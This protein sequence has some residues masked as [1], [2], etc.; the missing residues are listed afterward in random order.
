LGFYFFT[1]SNPR[2]YNRFTGKA[3]EEEDFFGDEE[4]DDEGTSF[5]HEMKHSES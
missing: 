2:N 5:L 4:E 1:S 3:L